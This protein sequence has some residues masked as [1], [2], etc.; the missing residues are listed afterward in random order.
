MQEKTVK[1]LNIGCDGCVRTIQKE[2]GA[3]S[4]VTAVIGN[5]Q[6]QLVTIHW[7]APADWEGIESTLTAIEYPPTPV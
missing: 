6:S 5:T 7:E 4:G 3:L 1:V 2:V